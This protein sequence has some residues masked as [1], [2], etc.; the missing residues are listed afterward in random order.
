LN[1]VI[2]EDVEFDEKAS[3]N[4]SL[5]KPKSQFRI[6]MHEQLSG[7]EFARFTGTMNVRSWKYLSQTFP[8]VCRDEGKANSI[9]FYIGIR[10]KVKKVKPQ[11]RTYTTLPAKPSQLINTGERHSSRPKHRRVGL[12][13]VRIVQGS[14]Q[15]QTTSSRGRTVFGTRKRTED[16]GNNKGQISKSLV[17]KT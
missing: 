3:S 2:G 9:F 15:T 6:V 4:S 12:A 17:R 8:L 7:S 1:F 13:I 14:N 10:D 11:V 5:D 16:T